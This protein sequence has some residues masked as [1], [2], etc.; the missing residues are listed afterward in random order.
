M[1]VNAVSM[2]TDTSFGRRMPSREDLESFAYADD[3]SLRT[4]ARIAAS[5][6]VNDD[7]HRKID[8]GIIMS[9]PVLSGLADM[10]SSKNIGRIPKLKAFTRTFAGTAIAL[11]VFSAAFELKDFFA[12]DSNVVGKFNKEHPFISDL[13]TL[14]VGYGGFLLADKGV[15]KLYEK[16]GKNVIKFLKH[17]NVDKFINENKLITN[18]MKQVR[19]LPPLIKSFAKSTVNLAPAIAVVTAIVHMFSHQAAK[20][21]ATQLNYYNL[22]NNQAQV[23]EVL[24]KADQD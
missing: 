5:S 9:L 10:I 1:L 17:N 3:K 18:T 6:Q 23:R 16:Y 22:K 2:N 20:N 11:G 7:K 12:K 24:A 15:S 14:G 19:K 8:A 21:A 4:M 13:A